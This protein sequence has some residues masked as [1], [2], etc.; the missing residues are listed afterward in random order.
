VR[1]VSLVWPSENFYIT[2]VDFGEVVRI[3]AVVTKGI[4]G[5]SYDEWVQKYMI[6]YSNTTWTQRTVPKS[7]GDV[8]F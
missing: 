6:K 4:G 5:T 3:K 8:S 7:P 1:F 2:Q